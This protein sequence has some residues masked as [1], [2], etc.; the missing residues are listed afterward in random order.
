MKKSL[1]QSRELHVT[2][3]HNYINHVTQFSFN[4]FVFCFCLSFFFAPL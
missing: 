1:S 4:F 3:V 2:F